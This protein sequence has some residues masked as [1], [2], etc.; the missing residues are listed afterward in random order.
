MSAIL[1]AILTA[2]ADFLGISIGFA[3]VLLAA[4][5]ALFGYLAIFTP[6]GKG[7]LRWLFIN[8]IGDSLDAATYTVSNLAGAADTV[9]KTFVAAFAGPGGKIVADLT[10]PMGDASEAALKA[11]SAH[12]VGAG[13]ITP[14][15]WQDHATDAMRDAFAFGLASFGATAAFEALFPEKLNTLNGIGPMLATMAGFEEVTAAW[16]RPLLTAAVQRPATYDANNRTRPMQ[17][18]EQAA[19]NLYSRGLIT[20]AA[21]KQ[22]LAYAG[23]PDADITSLMAGAFRPMSPFV[24]A[25][26]LSDGS[27]DDATLHNTLTF[28]GYRASDADLVLHAFHL[29][30]QQPYRQSALR[31]VKTAYQRGLITDADL[32]D[33]FKTLSIPTEVQGFIRLEMGYTKLVELSDLYRRGLDEA[34]QY[35]NEPLAR[36]VTDLEA[37]GLSKA[38]ADA[39]YAIVAAKVQGKDALAAERA[40]EAAARTTLR[41]KTQALM[42]Q[43]MAGTQSVAAIVPALV[44]LGYL[45]GNAAAIY[46]AWQARKQGHVRMVYGVVLKPPDAEVFRARADAIIE[47]VKKNLT[48]VAIAIHQLTALGIPAGEAAALANLAY[49]TA[50]AKAKTAPA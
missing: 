4:I 5:A 18:V 9:V 32:T 45:P 31:A 41:E 36:Y 20:A 27:I 3:G 13:N 10:K 44:A 42:N 35:H 24:M 16:L 6:T 29:R 22:F 37:I 2:I 50:Q 40:A 17:L 19:L 43:Y 28:G 25:A 15:Q 1:I 47:T 39:H 7:I 23:H 8:I 48:P 34:A 38:D 21:C 46:A 49:Q 30:M 12:L 14:P 11:V 33:A 26:S